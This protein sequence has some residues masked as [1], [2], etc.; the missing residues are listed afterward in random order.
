M[1]DEE[2]FGLGYD[3]LFVLQFFVHDVTIKTPACVGVV[4]NGNV[5]PAVIV[6]SYYRRGNQLRMRMG[7]RGSRFPAMVLKNGDE[8]EFGIFFQGVVPLLVR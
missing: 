8:L 6:G 1:K 5:E 2:F 3:S 7:Q 4:V